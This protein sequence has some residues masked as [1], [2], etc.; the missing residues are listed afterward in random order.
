MHHNNQLSKIV[1]KKDKKEEE[2]E[3]LEGGFNLYV[4]GAHKKN[5][6]YTPRLTTAKSSINSS[7]SSNKNFS[8]LNLESL[9]S[10]RSPSTT[11]A[12]TTRKKWSN[13]SFIF[14]TS[15]GCEIKINSPS[16]YQKAEIKTSNQRSR[17]K[18]NYLYAIPHSDI[19]ARKNIYI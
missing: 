15:D 16:H 14:K 3:K 7:S 8:K 12:V 1:K 17:Y 5:A 4:N 19:F 10:S 11:P 2:L 18:Y 9:N 6:K 13:S